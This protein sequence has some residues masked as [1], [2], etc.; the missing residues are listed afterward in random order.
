[1]DS[2]TVTGNYWVGI[3]SYGP[4]GVPG[5]NGNTL[6]EALYLPTPDRFRFQAL[7]RSDFNQTRADAIDKILAEDSDDIVYPF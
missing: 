3:V 6:T 5:A 4:N 7:S 1:M 2:A